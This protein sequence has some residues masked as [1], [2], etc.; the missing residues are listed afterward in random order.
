MKIQLDDKVVAK[1]IVMKIGEVPV[2]AL[3][4]SSSP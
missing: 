1:P 4:S 2:F 3:P